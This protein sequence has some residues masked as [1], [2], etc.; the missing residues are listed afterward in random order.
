MAE[1]T[2]RKSIVDAKY[3]DMRGA[4]DWIGKL[5]EEQ[6]LKTGIGAR[7]AVEEVRDAEGN[8]TQK[9]KPATKGKEAWDLDA[10]L[11]LAKTNFIDV[12]KYETKVAEFNE[13]PESHRGL[14]G[15][16]RMTISNMLRSR[17]RKRGGLFVN[18]EWMDAPEG[19]EVASP[20]TETRTG[21]PIK[22]EKPAKAA[23]GSETPADAEQETE[24]A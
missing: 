13:D 9:A 15:Q 19:F 17:A 10:L 5:M 11:N 3:K 14:V 8:V 20:L 7:P 4:S 23:E 12:A 1:E 2:Q 6:A 22:A 16:L 24:D 21:E 18:G